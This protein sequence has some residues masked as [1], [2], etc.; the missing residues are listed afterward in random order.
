MS[1]L[2]SWIRNSWSAVCRNGLLWMYILFGVCLVTANCIANKMLYVGNWFGEDIS[3]TAGIIVYPITFLITDIIGERYGKN[4]AMKAVVGGFGAQLVAMILIAIGGA[5][6]GSTVNPGF[7]EVSGAY[8]TIFSNG[9]LLVL[10][11]LVGCLVSQT[12]DVWVFHKIRS[13]WLQKHSSTAAGK[14]IWNNVST[15]T[16]Q[17][18]DS[19]I[20][21][22][23]AFGSQPWMT[24]KLFLITIFAYWVIKAGIALCDTPFF[25]LFTMKSRKAKKEATEQVCRC[26]DYPQGCEG[27]GECPSEHI[28]AKDADT[29][30]EKVEAPAV[31][32]E[33]IVEEVKAE[34]STKKEVV[35]P[36]TTPTHKATTRKTSAKKTEA[37]EVKE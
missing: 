6:P 14:W 5:I 24:A 8:T 31:T 21:Y 28:D 13:K 18:I 23:I 34:E 17:F 32:V 30:V 33:S 10:G 16:S 7:V 15:M 36:K 27:K 12:W 26:S 2:K 25:Y 29:E 35:K 9:Y 22:G 19:V 11:S 3:L 20:F 37:A 4:A 1:K